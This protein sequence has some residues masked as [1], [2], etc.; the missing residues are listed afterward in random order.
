[1]SWGEDKNTRGVVE[2]GNVIQVI[3]RFQ[4]KVEALS[5]LMND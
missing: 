3:G 2:G 5:S 1:M 4:R